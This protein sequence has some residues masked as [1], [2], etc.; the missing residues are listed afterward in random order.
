M[1]RI[2]F[3]ILSVFALLLSVPQMVSGNRELTSPTALPS[4]LETTFAGGNSQSGNYFQVDVA[5]TNGIDVTSMTG[6]FADVLSLGAGTVEVWVRDGVIGTVPGSTGWTQVATATIT[7]PAGT[8]WLAPSQQTFATNFSLAA[9]SH[10]FLF[11]YSENV[12]YTDGTAVGAV[13]A[14]D[15]NLTIYEGYGTADLQPDGTSAYA[16]FPRVWNGSFEYDVTSTTT[17]TTG[18]LQK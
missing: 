10:T 17:P 12:A 2:P 16:F 1:K 18:Q 11:S 8:S 6:N 7:V 4:S 3:F 14:Q 9:G 13:A 15:S 5:A